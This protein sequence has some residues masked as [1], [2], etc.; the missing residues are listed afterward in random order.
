MVSARVLS[1]GADTQ[2]VEILEHAD[3]EAGDVVDVTTKTK[4][5]DE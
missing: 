1:D 2:V 3:V 4:L 5:S